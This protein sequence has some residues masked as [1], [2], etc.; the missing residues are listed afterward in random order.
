MCCLRAFWD[1]LTCPQYS[2]LYPGWFSRCNDSMCLF[3]S[4]FILNGFQQTL[5][6]Q[7]LSS[8]L[9]WT[10]LETCS[11]IAART[12]KTVYVLNFC[13]VSK[14]SLTWLQ[15]HKSRN[16]IQDGLWYDWTLCVWICHVLVFLFYHKYYNTIHFAQSRTFAV[17]P[18]PQLQQLPLKSKTKIRIN[19]YST[20]S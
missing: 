8:T 11:S 3:K 4:L 5:Q 1:L 6:H 19:I 15:H 2:H 18:V 20:N 12:S 7:V 17:E 14:H 13:V 9:W 16:C 10:H